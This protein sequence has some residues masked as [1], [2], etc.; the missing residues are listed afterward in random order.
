M[1]KD[2]KIRKTRKK[3][4]MTPGIIAAAFLAALVI[5]GLLLYTE[6]KVLAGEETV[7]V[8]VASEE[9]KKGSIVDLSDDGCTQFVDIPVSL[10]PDKAYGP[11]DGSLPVVQGSMKAVQ[12]ISKGSVITE[13]MLKEEFDPRE[14]MKE[15]VLIGFKAEDYYQTAGGRIRPGDRIHIFLQDEE[16]NVSLRWS[17]VYVAD[18]FDSAGESIGE[19]DEGKTLRYNIYLEKKDVEEFY[20]KLDARMLRI[21]LASD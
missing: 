6:K 4:A 17:N 19:A 1:E 15:P 3:G 11:R 16:G 10:L 13:G 9:I 14:N 7:R 2:K 12:T 8:M 5:Y 20:K 21:A 18:S